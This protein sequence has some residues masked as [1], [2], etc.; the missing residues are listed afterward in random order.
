MISELLKLSF[1]QVDEAIILILSDGKICDVNSAAIALLKLSKEELLQKTIDDILPKFKLNYWRYLQSYKKILCPAQIAADQEEIKDIEVE[2]IYCQTNEGEGASLILK[3]VKMVEKLHKKSDQTQQNYVLERIINNIPQQIFWK[4]KNQV[5]LGCN[6][7]F[8]EAV[9]LDDPIE[10]IGKTDD[11][12]HRD[13]TQAQP[14]REW[15]RRV[16]EEGQ[17]I[18]DLE[19][20]YHNTD[21]TE[22]IVLMNKVPLTDEKGSIFGLVGICTDITNMQTMQN[23]VI[24]ANQLQGNSKTELE[25]TAQSRTEA[26]QENNQQLQYLENK[27]REALTTEQEINHLKT[28]IITTISHEYRTPLSR[29][30]MAAT[31]LQKYRQQLSDEK[32]QQYLQQIFSAVQY[33][34]NMVDDIVSLNSFPSQNRVLRFEQVNLIEV[35][36]TVLTQLRD[37]QPINHQLNLD[38]NEEEIWM[39]GD[40]TLLSHLLKNLL[41]NACQYSQDETIVTTRIYRHLDQIILEVSDEGIGIPDS[42]QDKLF[43]SFY[44][45]SNISNLRGSG[46]G[47]SIAKYAAEIHQGTITLQSQLGEG[48][49]F[50]VTFPFNHRVTSD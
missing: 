36:K 3:P 48:S 8:A 15:E 4:D 50:K 20:R 38:T 32:W 7:H 42:D 44:R 39:Q 35:Y 24:E 47:L 18:L 25:K 9:G 45:G 33:L 13:T 17:V 21:G 26:L 2:A 46:L 1:N 28:Q 12:L 14:Y 43:D 30:L 40:K 41:V 49:T 37:S 11:Q 5:Y 29:I 23:D 10:I 27:L 22:R 6:R 34:S 16:L 19:E 31:L